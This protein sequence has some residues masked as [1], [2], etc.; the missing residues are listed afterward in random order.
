MVLAHKNNNSGDFYEKIGRKL[1]SKQR[2]AGDFG[3]INVSLV[4]VKGVLFSLY[5]P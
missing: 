5:A 3:Y 1:C 2:T 4:S